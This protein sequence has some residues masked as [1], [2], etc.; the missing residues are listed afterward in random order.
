MRCSTNLG[1]PGCADRPDQQRPSNRG[2]KQGHGQREM[3]V[4]SEELDSDGTTVLQDEDE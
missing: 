3:C 2:Q 4:C 1:D